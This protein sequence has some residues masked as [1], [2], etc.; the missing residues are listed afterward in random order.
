MN[1][2]TRGLWLLLNLFCGALLAHTLF[3]WVAC[4]M[5]MPL[6]ITNIL[7]IK[8]YYFVYIGPPDL[9]PRSIILFVHLFMRLIR[10]EDFSSMITIG[11]MDHCHHSSMFPKDISPLG[12][13]RHHLVYNGNSFISSIINRITIK[14]FLNI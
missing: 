2:L 6:L 14:P 11:I 1:P 7:T 10:V 9:H 8:R 3:L 5:Q 4:D 13:L 12:C